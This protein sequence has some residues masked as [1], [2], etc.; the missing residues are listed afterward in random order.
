[1]IFSLHA[2][3][4]SFCQQEPGLAIVAFERPTEGVEEVGVQLKPGVQRLGRSLRTSRN[5][6][7]G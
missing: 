5:I 1:M 6:S 2:F 3:L 7:K 4:M